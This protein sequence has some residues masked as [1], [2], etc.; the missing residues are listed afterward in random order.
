MGLKHILRRL[1]RFP[2]FTAITLATLGIGIGGN[3]AIFTVSK[4]CC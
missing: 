3:S 4:A 2:T 1:I